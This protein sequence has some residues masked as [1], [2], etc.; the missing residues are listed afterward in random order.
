MALML[1]AA[2]SDLPTPSVVVEPTAPQPVTTLAP[3]RTADVQPAVPSPT[4]AVPTI[5]PTPTIATPTPDPL[6]AF[7]AELRPA[8]VADLAAYPDLPRYT[9]RLWLDPAE[10]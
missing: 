1:L 4:A 8:F 9:L 5:T 2:C 10:R 7:A 3:A 6:D